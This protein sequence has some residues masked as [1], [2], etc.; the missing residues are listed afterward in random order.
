M[1]HLVTNE[2]NLE[3]YINKTLNTNKET[4]AE[5]FKQLHIDL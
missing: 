2:L 3:N 4:F 1:T 5:Y